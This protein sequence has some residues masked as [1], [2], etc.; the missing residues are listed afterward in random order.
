M[1]GG[2]G[3]GE[4]PAGRRLSQLHA[5]EPACVLSARTLLRRFCGFGCCG[6]TDSR[7][8]ALARRPCRRRGPRGPCA[9][10]AFESA[11]VRFPGRAPTWSWNRAS[12]LY[13][14]PPALGWPE[15]NPSAHFSRRLRAQAAWPAGDRFAPR[16]ERSVRSRFPVDGSG[17]WPRDPRS[18]LAPRRVGGG[19]ISNC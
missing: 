5:Q 4:G 3:G 18:H 11:T 17:G 1:G 12:P 16:W 15:V 8:C 6:W 10:S 2:G 7:A 9:P 14:I 19:W 13:H